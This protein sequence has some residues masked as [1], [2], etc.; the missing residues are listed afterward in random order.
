[1]EQRMNY[2]MICIMEVAQCLQV[3]VTL[4]YKQHAEVSST[5]ELQWAEV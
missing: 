2:M 3:R 1:M 4:G 5:K